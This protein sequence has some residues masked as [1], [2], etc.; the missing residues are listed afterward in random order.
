MK[1]SALLFPVLA[2]VTYAAPA[3]ID[4]RE[5]EGRADGA[6]GPAGGSLNELFRVE[7]DV[8]VGP[9]GY[10]DKDGF[11]P[12]QYKKPGK[13]DAAPENEER[14]YYRYDGLRVLGPGWRVRYGVL[15]GPNAWWGPDG[16][17]WG[18]YPYGPGYFW[19]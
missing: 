2:A 7:G 10:Y 11:H 17:H 18:H 19:W 4:D 14:Q 3:N 16:W 13:R 9:G 1:V 5:L 6:L 8:L 15:I 12:S